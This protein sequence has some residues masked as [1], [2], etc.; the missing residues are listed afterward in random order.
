M[1]QLIAFPTV[2]GQLGKKTNNL[3]VCDTDIAQADIANL[4]Q[5][6][7]ESQEI[8]EGDILML[9]FTDGSDLYKVDTGF[10]LKLYSHA[11]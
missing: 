5:E 6:I 9:T 3:F 7:L 4:T 2:V 11:V 1:A 10:A 8:K